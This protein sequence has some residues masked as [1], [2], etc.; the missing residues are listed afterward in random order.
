M[1]WLAQADIKKIPQTGWL[2]QQE[3]I[4]H[5]LEAG[6]SKIKVSADAFPSRSCFPGMQMTV[7]PTAERLRALVSL[8]VLMGV[9]IPSWGFQPHDLS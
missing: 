1:S 6:K 2:R 5:S 7:C 3:F 9:T 8:P 4:S